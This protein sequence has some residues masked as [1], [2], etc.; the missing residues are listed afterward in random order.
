LH[1]RVFGDR[2][3]ENRDRS[4][5]IF[6]DGTLDQVF[7]SLEKSLDLEFCP[8]GQAIVGD[9]PRRSELEAMLTCELIHPRSA[10][11]GDPFACKRI[12]LLITLDLAKTGNAGVYRK[13]FRIE[14]RNLLS[15]RLRGEYDFASPLRFDE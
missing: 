15:R 12:D 11:F 7:E 13:D 9:G 5:H 4:I 3:R 6:E 2:D 1:E 14:K 8:C 10:G